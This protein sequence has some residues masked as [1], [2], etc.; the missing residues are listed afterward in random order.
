[1]RT[2]PLFIVGVLFAFS[3]LPAATV[4]FG[5]G[6]LQSVPADGIACGA[7]G[8]VVFVTTKQGYLFRSEDSGRSFVELKGFHPS[9]LGAVPADSVACSA[10]GEIV[11]VLIP[12]MQVIKATDGARNGLKSFV[13][14]KS[15]GNQQATGVVNPVRITCSPDG[16]VVYVIDIKGQLHQSTNGGEGIKSFLRL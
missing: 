15:T 2:L 7:E 10:D 1:M 11:Y 5:S 14:L 9:L 3:A 12:G 16:Q 6:T 4:R 13:L 8:R